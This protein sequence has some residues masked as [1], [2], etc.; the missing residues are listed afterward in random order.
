M[1]SYPSISDKINYKIDVIAFDKYDGSNI[2]AEWSQKRGFY[3]FGSRK[4]LLDEADTHLGNAITIF[5]KQWAEILP[6]IFYQ[7]GW[8][9][10]EMRVTCFFEYYGPNSFAGWHSDKPEDFNLSLIDVNLHKKGILEPKEFIKIFGDLEIPPVLYRGKANKTFIDRVRNSALDGMTEEGVVCKAPNPSRK[11][12]SKP[13]MFKIK[14]QAWYNKLFAK[15]KGD[16]KK[17][18]ELK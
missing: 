9:G 18:D 3:K 8:L 10:K 5:N 4:R 14:S 1:K 17:F 7:Q 13:V 2:R 16:L 11:R 12:T 6:E 15:C